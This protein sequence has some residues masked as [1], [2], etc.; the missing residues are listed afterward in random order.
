MILIDHIYQNA[1]FK[2]VTLIHLSGFKTPAGV[3]AV[4]GLHVLPVWLY[5]L[6]SHLWTPF[7]SHHL[8]MGVTGVLVSGRA[9]C[10]AVEVSVVICCSN[11]NEKT[12]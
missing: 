11:Q 3:F 7:M 1:Y 12:S 6:K 9:L 8:Q 5:G 10:M 4:S 2:V